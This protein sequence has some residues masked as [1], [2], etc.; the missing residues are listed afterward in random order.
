MANSKQLAGLV[1]PAIIVLTVSEL[2]NYSIWA[3]NIPPNT[4]LNGI[5]LFIAGLAI[6]RVHNIWRGWPVLLTLAGWLYLIFGLFRVFFPRAK[7][8]PESNSI[9][10]GLI[11]LCL[12]GVFL[13]YKAYFP[14][15]KNSDTKPG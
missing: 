6:I 1:G 11:V 13:T 15:R 10:A 7:Q 3:I 5:L 8:A 4:Y 12:A 2:M 9:Y 14:V